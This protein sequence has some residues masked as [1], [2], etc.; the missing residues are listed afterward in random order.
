M[1][2]LVDWGKKLAVVVAGIGALWTVL[3]FLDI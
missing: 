2:L 3:S 1:T